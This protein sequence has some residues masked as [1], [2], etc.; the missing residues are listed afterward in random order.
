ESQLDFPLGQSDPLSPRK[1]GTRPTE[2]NQMKRNWIGTVAYLAFLACMTATLAYGQTN[3]DKVKIKGLIT[4]RTGETLIL[5]TGNAGE[6][7]V[8]LT[9]DTKVQK[10]KG[11]GLRHTQMSMAALIPGLK[12]EI[13]GV[14]DARTQ[15][16][17]Q[18]I[19]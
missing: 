6:I 3:G 19:N 7:V 18:T 15:V 1:K 11:L 17:A 13:D 5:R 2:G 9:D 14:G 16:V 4:G 8:V 10:P 12:V